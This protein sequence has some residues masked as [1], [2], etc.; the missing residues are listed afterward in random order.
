MT[1][2]SEE[3]AQ[4]RADRSQ[5]SAHHQAGR[6]ARRATE[7]AQAEEL[8]VAFAKRALA[9]GEP[10]EEL[11]VRPWSGRG[12]Y[13]TGVMGWY[14]RREPRVAVGVDRNYYLLTVPPVRFG[15]WRRYELGPTPPPLIVGEGGRDGEAIQLDDLLD[16]RLRKASS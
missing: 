15:R 9:E 16:L 11:L 8:I 13:R 7:S 6:G 4:R 2:S 5:R 10:P 3:L 14:L 12:L 1:W